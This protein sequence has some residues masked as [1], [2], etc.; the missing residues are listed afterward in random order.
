MTRPAPRVPRTTAQ[1][2]R[3][4][5][6][7]RIAFG[8]IVV[9]VLAQAAWWIVFEFRNIASVSRRTIDAWQ[10]DAAYAN[11]LLG[12]DD[13]LV[14][15]VLDAYPHLALETRVGAGGEQ[16]ERVV[17]DP[18]HLAAFQAAQRA[19]RRM[20]AFEGPTFALVVLLMLLFIARS[21]RSE[22]ELKRRQQNFLSAVTHE[23][24]TPIST[25]RLLVQ[26]VLMRS[27][28]ADKHRDYMERM[29]VELGRLA[30]TSEQVLASA[31]LEQATTPPALQDVELNHALQ[32]LIGRARGGL[33][34]RGAALSVDYAAEDLHVAVDLDGLALVLNNLLDNAV[35]YSV[36]SHRPVR[37][38][39]EGR[40]DLVEIH[41]D[42]E[43][44]GLN[45]GEE[46]LVFERFYRVGDE[47]T[48]ESSG[49][50]LGLHLVRSV[51]EAMNGWVRA[52]PNPD[53][54]RGS[55]FTIVLPRRVESEPAAAV[56]AA[57]PPLIT[58]GRWQ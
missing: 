51:T 9:F 12:T 47:L 19:Q 4:Q 13:E 38:R 17:V 29:E 40:P 15:R 49:V 54:P 56:R 39:L 27:L 30:R 34:A 3:R 44:I 46:R 2:R 35:K 37:V 53:A 55:R 20:F 8:V 31:R 57:Q 1:D 18:Q 45:E 58:Q 36:G 21:L 33:E 25:L 16:V 28:P 6:A 14:P 48:R 5:L 50:G 43:G 26:T 42:D 7:T 41:V 10:R 23:L 24:K 32:G 22:R 52:G 11:T